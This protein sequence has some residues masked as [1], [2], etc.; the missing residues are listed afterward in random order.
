MK[1]STLKVAALACAGIISVA[2]P[3]PGLAEPVGKMTAVQTQVNKAGVGAIGVGSGISLGDRLASNATGLGLILFNDQS[4]VKIG[5]NSKLTIDEFVYSPGGFG[6]FGI[7][8]DR[9]VSRFFGG[10][11]SKKG[12]MRITTP[13]VILGVRGGI[14]DIEVIVRLSTAILRAGKLTCRLGDEVRVITKTG[15]GCTSDGRSIDVMKIQSALKI[16]DSPA[17]TAGTDEPGDKGP[18]LQVDAGCAAA[19]AYL[20]AACQSANG[21]LPTPGSAGNYPGGFNGNDGTPRPGPLESLDNCGGD[22]VC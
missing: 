22:D 17:R 12:Q 20:N 15:F 19:G 4:S 10:Q 3:A 21:Q 14:V 9:G 2:L 6:D 1:I 13:H 8:M 5:P 11:V 7:S 18:G 16:L